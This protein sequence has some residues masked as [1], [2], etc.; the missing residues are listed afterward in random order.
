M[1]YL[2]VP[3]N[4]S[5]SHIAK[6]LAIRKGLISCGHK[7]K[8]AV[9]QRWSTYLRQNNIPFAILPTIQEEDHAAFPSVAWFHDPK[10]IHQVI[11]AERCLIE[12]Y[13]PDRVLGIFRFTTKAA[14]QLANV[15]YD[16]M[17]CGCLIPGA[18]DAY[19]YSPGETGEREQAALMSGFFR[20]AGSK[21][22]K[23]LE[24]VGLD[25]ITDV[26]NML[27]GERTFLWDF[28]E[29]SPYSLPSSCQYV[30]MPDW[31]DWPIDTNKHPDLEPFD[32]R[33]LA[34][35]S[36]GTCVGDR[37]IARDITHHLGE[38]GFHVLLAA[39]GQQKL[40]EEIIPK[41]WISVYQFAPLHKIWSKVSLLVSHGGQATLFEAIKHRVPVAIIPFQP[42]QA[43]NGVSMEMLGCGRR[44]SPGLPFLGNSNIYADAFLAR[45]KE[46]F[47]HIIAD[48]MSTQTAQALIKTSQKLACYR[49]IE[50]LLP[51]L[52]ETA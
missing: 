47:E 49:G 40:H 34:V 7:V 50:D 17:A 44:L 15:P 11:A 3:E 5:L 6:A 35:I 12:A 31:N 52:Q 32:G 1:R 20:Y 10:S 48:L 36:F 26:R 19:G 42:E 39:G 33:P 29:F 28:P 37:K 16:S 51:R 23:A 30:G 41:P 21:M 27:L 45:G 46:R 2:L 14:A 24:A 25:P 38:L 8:L 43:H 9:G 13:R 4:N 22:S 18:C